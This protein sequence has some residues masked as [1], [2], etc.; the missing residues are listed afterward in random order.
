ML[1]KGQFKDLLKEIITVSNQTTIDKEGVDNAIDTYTQKFED[2][3]Y[4]TIKSIEII[5]PPGSIVVEGSPT[6]QTNVVQIILNKTI[7]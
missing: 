1:V 6:T 7:L 4:E 5:I 3:I 2:L